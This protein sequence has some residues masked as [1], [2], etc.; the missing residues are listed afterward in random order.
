MR[1]AWQR[2]HRLCQSLESTWC[3]VLKNNNP[4]SFEAFPKGKP[5]PPHPL[6]TKTRDLDQTMKQCKT[7]P[8][9]TLCPACHG[10][11][12]KARASHFSRCGHEPVDSSRQNQGLAMAENA[13]ISCRSWRELCV[14]EQQ[15]GKKPLILGPHK[16]DFASSINQVIWNQLP[17]VPKLG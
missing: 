17:N 13:T 1:Q 12:V 6:E 2:R 5:H 8:K 3:Q 11:K 4:Q 14:P 7:F 10:F 9:D 16:S 15:S